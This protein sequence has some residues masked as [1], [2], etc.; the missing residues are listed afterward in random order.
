[1]E[2]QIKWGRTCETWKEGGRE[3]GWGERERAREINNESESGAE[4]ET[5][6]LSEMATQVIV[7][8]LHVLY[9]ACMY[10]SLLSWY[11]LVA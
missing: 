7:Y 8:S 6:L 2:R 5:A 3:R 1:L 9:I 11:E 10:F 4:E